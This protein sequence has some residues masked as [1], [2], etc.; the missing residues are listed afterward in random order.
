MK[1]KRTRQDIMKH[2]FGVG[3]Y[4]ALVCP[5]ITHDS[6]IYFY[7]RTENGQGYAYIGKS[8]DVLKRCIDHHTRFD[9]HID[10]SLKTRKYYSKNNQGGWKLNVLYFPKE[11]LDQ[12]ESYYIE[13]YKNAGYQVYNIESGGTKGKEIIGQRKPPKTYT[14]GKAQGEKNTIKQVKEFFDKYLDYS[15]KEP[16]NKIKQKKLEQFKELLGK[17]E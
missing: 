17:T 6:G 5:N 1:E 13:K 16:T 11:L 15:I 10:K 3:Q 7:T 4:L 9:Q 14:E 8:V 12:K 2:N